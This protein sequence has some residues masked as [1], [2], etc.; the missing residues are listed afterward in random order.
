MSL[1]R[2][3]IIIRQSNIILKSVCG[4][5]KKNMN[6]NIV[7]LFTDSLLAVFLESIGKKE[8]LI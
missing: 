8:F 3:Y 6:M 5:N 4:T 2:I 1:V 7:V